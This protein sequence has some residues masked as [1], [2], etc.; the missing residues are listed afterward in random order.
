MLLETRIACRATR[1]ELAVY[2]P[3]GLQILEDRNEVGEPIYR[4]LY[5]FRSQDERRVV[6][7]MMNKLGN[8]MFKLKGI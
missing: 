1:E 6:L 8:G 5:N 7:W 3:D 2:I 4:V